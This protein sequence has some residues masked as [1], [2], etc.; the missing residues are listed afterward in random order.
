MPELTRRGLL[1]GSAATALALQVG[2]AARAQSGN[3]LIIGNQ[4]AQTHF[5]PHA[6]QDY[7]TS[8]IIRNVYDG[9]VDAVGSPPRIIPRLADSWTI[10][11][12]GRVYT[13]SLNP[14]AKFHDGSPVTAEAVKYSFDR[15]RGVGRG[16]SWMIDGVI[17]DESIRVVD[18]KTVEFTLI[19]PFAPFL[20]V[21]PWISVVN[22]ALIEAN[23][24]SDMGQT[25]LLNNTAGSGPFTVARFEPENVIDFSRDPTYWREG[26]GNT[27]T[28]IWR[29]VRENT[30]QRLMLQRGEIHMAVDL[31]S[32]DMKA[33]D[34][35]PGV[36]Q[37]IEP[38]DR[39]FSI[40]MNTEFGPTSDLNL[41]K[42]ISYAFDYDAMLAVTGYGELMHGPLHHGFFGH[43]ASIEVPR[44]D[45]AK[46][47]E[48]LA[49]TEFPEGGITLDAVYVTGLEQS[50]LWCLVLL[51]SLRELNIDLNIRPSTWPDMVAMCQS[52]E[53]FPAFFC[54]Y[55][56]VQYAD[57]DVIA[58]AGYHSSRN[59]GWQNA[60]YNNPEVDALIEAARFEP[61]Q[62]KRAALYSQVQ[63]AIVADAPDIFGIIE[64][65]KVGMRDNVGGFEF[66][67]LV[68][69]AVSFFPLSVS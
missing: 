40:K 32:D 29:Y 28:V 31:T 39:T 1:A 60:V 56:G 20:S 18:D 6:G 55:L 64:K 17:G 26:G 22:P 65:A 49:M 41:R 11:D 10:S 68:V 57:P 69:Q 21:L 36:V 59:G 43:D 63:T 50:R 27:D 45:L 30:N 24:G 61:D 42:A 67:P 66:S 33:L 3:V 35:V 51:D 54:V 44:K 9:L 25:Y 8:V 7:P 23:A 62:A 37:V 47:K 14:G 5:D 58:Y 48:F 38:G 34:G 53:T 12:D 52:P 2:G 19:Q 4:G 16:N 15:I 13:F 46:A